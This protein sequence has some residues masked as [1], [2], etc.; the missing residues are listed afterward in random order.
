LGGDY[1][2]QGKRARAEMLSRSFEEYEVLVRQE[3]LDVFGAAGF[4]PAEDIEGIA[5]NRFGHAEVV[6]YP[7][8]A[9]RSGSSVEP[10]PGMPIYDA[11]QRFGRIAFAHTDLFGF[12]DNQGTTMVSWRAVNE[13]LE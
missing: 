4:D 9:F 6:C 5:I 13:L 3:L 10:R 12:A 2:E 7:G 11:G 8:F 1:K